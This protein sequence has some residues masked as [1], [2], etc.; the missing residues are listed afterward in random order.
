MTDAGPGT[1]TTHTAV[2]LIPAPEVWEPIQVIRRRH[3][4]QIDRWMP[5]V[6]LL[7]P[8]WPRARF[9]E[10]QALLA[11]ACARVPSF[12]VTLRT[13]GSFAQKKTS[14]MWLAPEPADRL[15]ALHAA[16]LAAVPDCD[17][18][19]RHAAGFTA[20]LSVGQLDRAADV[21]RV[22]GELQAGW[23]PLT[24][25]AAAVALIARE[26]DQPFAVDR[27]IA[28]GAVSSSA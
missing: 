7:Y 27:T 6:T 5:H 3:D 4:R 9:D 16:L 25:A 11:P 23:S 28:L 26:G 13:F 18:T 21:A 8:F 15:R 1:K 17:D 20:H 19:A 10:A 22:L 12:P 14:T 2:V 24:F